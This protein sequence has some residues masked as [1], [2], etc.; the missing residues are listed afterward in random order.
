MP[1]ACAGFFTG[2]EGGGGGGRGRKNLCI[3]MMRFTPGP[4]N[5]V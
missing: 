3:P 4:T 5:L 2:G 1:G